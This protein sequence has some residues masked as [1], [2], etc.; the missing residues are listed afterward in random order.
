[1]CVVPAALGP[2]RALISARQFA[3]SSRIW[4]GR[5]TRDM[6]TRSAWRS[7]SDAVIA[8]IFAMRFA[9]RGR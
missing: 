9:G 5:R 4:T 8:L 3:R 1:M 7:T 6:D 2:P